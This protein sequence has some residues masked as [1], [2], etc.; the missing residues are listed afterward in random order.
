MGIL[1]TR[2]DGCI[3]S[4]GEALFGLSLELDGFLEAAQKRLHSVWL[5]EMLCLVYIYI[6]PDV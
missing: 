2:F 1:R 4:F 6:Y 5:D 3:W